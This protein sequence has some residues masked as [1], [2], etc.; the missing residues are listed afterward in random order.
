MKRDDFSIYD[1][2]KQDIERLDDWYTLAG[3]RAA[4]RP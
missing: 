1:A 3:G 4:R 2:S